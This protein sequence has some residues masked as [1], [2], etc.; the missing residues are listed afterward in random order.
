MLLVIGISHGMP[1]AS[2]FDLFAEPIP[3]QFEMFKFMIP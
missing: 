3:T 2:M 1:S